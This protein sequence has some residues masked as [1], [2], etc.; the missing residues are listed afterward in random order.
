[1]K[2][3]NNFNGSL[4]FVMQFYKPGAFIAKNDPSLTF[5][6]HAIKW[7]QRK[8]IAATLIGVALAASAIAIGYVAIYEPK[9]TDPTAIQSTSAQPATV[10]NEEKSMRIEFNDAPLAIVVPEI[11]KVYDVKIEGLSP[12]DTHRITLSYEGTAADLIATINETLGTNLTIA[13]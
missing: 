10:S 2:T 13:K 3:N 11:E 5:T 12:N 4:R 9:H 7:W 6:T 1:M 8:S